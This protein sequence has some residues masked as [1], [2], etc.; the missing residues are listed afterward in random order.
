MVGVTKPSVTAVCE[1]MQ[2]GDLRVFERPKRSI[3]DEARAGLR[4]VD[5]D[6]DRA[7][8]NRLRLHDHVAALPVDPWLAPFL[9][10]F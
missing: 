1:P 2:A 10:T 3:S 4:R 5:L 6:G 7:G 8:H 9:H